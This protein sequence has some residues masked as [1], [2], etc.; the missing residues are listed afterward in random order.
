MVMICYTAFMMMLVLC[1]SMVSFAALRKPDKVPDLFADYYDTER[2]LAQLVVAVVTAILE[3]VFTLM[4]ILL[5]VN[6]ANPMLKD[7]I[8]V[9]AVIN[10]VTAFF[11]VPVLRRDMY[12]KRWYLALTTAYT[13]VEFAVV[14]WTFIYRL[15]EIF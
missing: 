3:M 1:L 6:L 14:G 7:T 8:I 5:G 11:T 9:L 15:G 13:L 10:T 2:V 12:R 4:L